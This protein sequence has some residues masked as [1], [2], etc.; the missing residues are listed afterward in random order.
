M[1]SERE[2]D[3]Y[4][5]QQT[6]FAQ[7]KLNKI[8]SRL[9]SDSYCTHFTLIVIQAIRDYILEPEYELK[10]SN[11]VFN[12][13]YYTAEMFITGEAQSTLK[14]VVPT[15]DEA[16]PKRVQAVFKGQKWSFEPCDI[17]SN[18]TVLR[19]R[20]HKP[21]LT[22]D[23]VLELAN[24][25]SRLW[26]KLKKEILNIAAKHDTTEEQAQLYLL[27]RQ[28]KQRERKEQVIEI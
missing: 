1:T 27:R 9:P 23:E 5:K 25:P 14:I 24:I 16:Q 20:A 7:E 11:I 10:H 18:E 4:I 6:Q 12:Q 19:E 2:L 15:Q 8:L 22:Q 13:N 26:I 21:P 17:T 28:R 3:N